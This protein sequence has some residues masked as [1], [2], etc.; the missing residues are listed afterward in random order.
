MFLASFPSG[1]FDANCYLVAAEGTT[2]CV[3]IDA[4]QDAFDTIVELCREHGL[5]PAAVV[6]THGHLDHVADA[7]AVGEHWQVPCWIHP[8]DRGLLADPLSGLGPQLAPMVAPFL[9]AHGDVLPTTVAELT[10]GERVAV[11]GVGL[12]VVEAPGHTP[13][14]VVLTLDVPTEPNTPPVAFTGDVVFA[15]SVGRT[16]LPGGDPATMAATLARLVAELDPATVLLPGHGP[17][18]TLADE[19]RRNP[20]LPSA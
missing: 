15:G 11:A 10:A 19:I 16:D 18:T 8:G 14:S 6:A 1:A 17:R 7:A 9:A 3:V 12:T 13:G 20:H 2:E 4:G 5:T